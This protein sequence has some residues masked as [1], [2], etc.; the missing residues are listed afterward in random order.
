MSTKFS[1]ATKHTADE[2][3]ALSQMLDRK[4]E[5]WSDSIARHPDSPNKDVT[6]GFINKESDKPGVDLVIDVLAPPNEQKALLRTWGIECVPDSDG[7]ER[8]NNI[9]LSYVVDYATARELVVK[10]KALTRDDIEKF[11]HSSKHQLDRIVISD[12]TGRDKSSQQ[13]LGNRYDLDSEGLS[14]LTE[15]AIAELAQTMEKVLE[16]LKQSAISEVEG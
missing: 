10:D 7:N 15:D 16:R 12:Q 11:L 8:F 6:A 4:M 2:L 9:Q 1:E 3:I 13:L 14:N 5:T